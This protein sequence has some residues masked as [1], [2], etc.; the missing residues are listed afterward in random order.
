MLSEICSHLCTVSTS[1]IFLL[2]A[3]NIEDNNVKTCKKLES[4]VKKENSKSIQIKLNNHGFKV[5]KNVDGDNMVDKWDNRDLM[6][7]ALKFNL[8]L[9]VVDEKKMISYLL[10]LIG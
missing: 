9:D 2:L 10:I 8:E 6:K 4:S 5:F 3:E 1:K 7:K